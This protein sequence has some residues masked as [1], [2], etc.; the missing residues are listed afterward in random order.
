MHDIQQPFGQG[1]KDTNPVDVKWQETLDKAAAGV[2]SVKFCHTWPF[3]GETAGSSEATGFVVHAT[4]GSSCSPVI[5]IHGQAVAMQAGG[6]AK[7]ATDY[8]LPLDRPMR[9]LK[10][11]QKGE[12]ITR[13]TIQCQRKFKPFNEC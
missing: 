2:V 9:A 4:G 7:A 1:S 8:F 11:F 3:D 12:L 13:G 5:N 6:K 10:G